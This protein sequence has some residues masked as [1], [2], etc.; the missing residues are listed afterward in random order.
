MKILNLVLDVLIKL[1]IAYGL[2]VVAVTLLDM[3]VLIPYRLFRG[4]TKMPV[5]VATDIPEKVV[6]KS[7]PAN[8]KV[9]SPE[10]DAGFVM[11]RRF[12]YGEKM[13]KRSFNSKMTV[14]STRGKKDAE[15]V[16]DTF[17][18]KSD[19]FDF[20]NCIVDHNLTDSLGRKLDFRN[21]K[22]VKALSGQVAEEIQTAMDKLNNFEDDDDLGN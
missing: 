17:N 4:R 11:I 2:T 21:E 10:G 15:S 18:E 3:F 22:D 14:K 16:I 12:S 9:P 1:L 6:L 5:A 8:P 7:L 20:A 19:L 13:A